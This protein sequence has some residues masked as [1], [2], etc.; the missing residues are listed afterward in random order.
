M[1]KKTA[2]QSTGVVPQEGKSLTPKVLRFVDEYLKDLNATQAAVRAGYSKRT[3]KQQGS[4]LLTNADVQ[5]QVEIARKELAVNAGITRE[6]ILA[7]MAKIAFSDLRD[8]YNEDGTL[9]MPHEWPE[10]AA[11]AIASMEFETMQLGGGGD[12]DAV[13]VS[14]RV[15]KVK[16]WDKGKQLENLLKHL[17]MAEDKPPE[18]AQTVG[19]IPEQLAAVLERAA[20]FNAAPP[21]P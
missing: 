7:E 1:T 13:P 8:L 6:R 4:R 2:T 14:K 17:G 10:G 12:D 21:A 18:A 15:A 19:V 5:R 20:K 16:V 3:A 9:R 11:G